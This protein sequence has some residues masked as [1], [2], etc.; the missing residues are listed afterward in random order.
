MTGANILFQWSTSIFHVLV[1]AILSFSHCV[2]LYSAAFDL[3]ASCKT[4]RSG[5]RM[6]QRQLTLEPDKPYEAAEWLRRVLRAWCLGL[7]GFGQRVRVSGPSYTDAQTR[8]VQMLE[9]DAT[10]DLWFQT[11]VSLSGIDHGLWHFIWFQGGGLLKP[12]GPLLSHARGLYRVQGL[13]IRG[14]GKV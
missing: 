2:G 4:P 10:E 14:L 6:R 12:A 13:G 1:Y 8:W 5:T 7:G 11:I 3:A 9:K